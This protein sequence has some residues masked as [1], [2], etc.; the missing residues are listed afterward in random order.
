MEAVSVLDRNV[1]E[2][3]GRRMD[4]AVVLADAGISPRY[5]NW[6]LRDAAL[7]VGADLVALSRK[8]VEALQR[9]SPVS[10]R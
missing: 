3:V 1:R 2:V 4:V 8:L 9:P 10:L 5:A 6:Q 7:D